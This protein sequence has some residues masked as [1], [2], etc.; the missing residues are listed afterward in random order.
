MQTPSAS[1]F[2]KRPF[3]EDFFVAKHEKGE[4]QLHQTRSKMHYLLELLQKEAT[5]KLPVI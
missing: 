1:K 4:M 3:W 5:C 2:W